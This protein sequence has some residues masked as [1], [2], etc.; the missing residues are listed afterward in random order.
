VWG[1]GLQSGT[2]D[3]KMRLRITKWG[4]GLQSVAYDYKV[5]LEDNINKLNFFK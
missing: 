1:L 3:Y 2:Q 4:L 5:G